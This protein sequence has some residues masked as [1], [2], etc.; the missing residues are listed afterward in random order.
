MPFRVPTFNLSCNIW[1]DNVGQP[2]YPIVA[3]P[4]VISPCQLRELKTAFL[5]TGNVLYSMLLA[6]PL[7]TDIRGPTR[8]TGAFANG[9]AV[10]VPA[11][12][13]RFYACAYVD[14]VA[15]GFAN[16]Y[17]TAAL[18]ALINRV[19]AWPTPLP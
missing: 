15:R 19:G 8:F 17:R 1:T 4:R 6:I 7:R 16:E 12:S 2:V 11:G 18:T 3:A 13:G 14:D 10:E 9:D 5:V